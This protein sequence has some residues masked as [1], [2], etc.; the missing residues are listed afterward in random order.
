MGNISRQ[1]LA[2]VIFQGWSNH[3]QSLIGKDKVD[4]VA[5]FQFD[6]LSERRQK[7]FFTM[8]DSVIKFLSDSF[9]EKSE[10]KLK[11]ITL[12]S[13][14]I[15]EMINLYLKHICIEHKEIDIVYFSGD[16]S[17]DQELDTLVGYIDF[18]C[19]E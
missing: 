12:N 4:Q 5:F 3:Q 2:Q 15:V 16:Y 7:E 6:Q 17:P 9:Q 11:R 13:S 18:K 19:N 8:A 10:V 14:Q 1:D